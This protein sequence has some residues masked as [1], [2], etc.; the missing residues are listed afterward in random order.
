M[1][2]HFNFNSKIS[3]WSL[4]SIFLHFTK[5]VYHNIPLFVFHL[6][7]WWDNHVF[8]YSTWEVKSP[9]HKK[10]TTL[11]V[12]LLH[13]VRVT[14]SLSLEVDYKAVILAVFLGLA[15]T[16]HVC[17]KELQPAVV[18]LPSHI[19]NRTISPA[20]YVMVPRDNRQPRPSGRRGSC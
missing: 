8:N 9:M 17:T 10:K 13:A 5:S 12:Q 2:F 18:Y 20:P 7:I 3:I 11:P 19:Q 6:K 15:G 1:A 14:F 16:L 4:L